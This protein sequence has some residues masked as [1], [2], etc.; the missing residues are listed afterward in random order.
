M[1]KKLNVITEIHKTMTEF[2]SSIKIKK[3]DSNINLNIYN[4]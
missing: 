4:D 3:C 2:L 1:N